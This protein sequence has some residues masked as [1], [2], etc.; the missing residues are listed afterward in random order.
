LPGR[1]RAA[2]KILDAR[3]LGG[4]HRRLAC[5]AHA[6]KIAV[7]VEARRRFGE[8]REQALA[9]E[10]PLK[11]VGHSLR[12]LDRLDENVGRDFPALPAPAAALERGHG[13]LVPAAAVVE[14]RE[15]AFGQLFHLLP[16]EDDGAARGVH[17]FAAKGLHAFADL[18]HGA[19][20]GQDD[21][22]VGPQA[23][24]QVLVLRQEPHAFPAE[25]FVDR[26]IV[27]DGARQEDA[28]RRSGRR[29]FS[30]QA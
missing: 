19:E 11:E 16:D 1:V 2:E 26:G 3:R 20:R 21:D 29:C 30:S 28:T 6:A 27:E 7:R 12:V 17:D 4:E 24:P 23:V 8:A 25:V 22:V 14:D 13:L 15:A 9:V 18:R 5:E 10:P